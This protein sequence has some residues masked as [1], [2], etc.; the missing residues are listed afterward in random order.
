MTLTL[1]VTSV[2]I[3]I[4]AAD[5]VSLIFATRAVVVVLVAIVILGSV[6]ISGNWDLW[7]QGE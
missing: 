7:E 3:A 6:I 1:L 2:I 5:V 4:L